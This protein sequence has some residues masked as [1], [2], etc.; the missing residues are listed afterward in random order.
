MRPK[1]VDLGFGDILSA[2]NE[3]HKYSLGGSVAV[4][5]VQV[6]VALDVDL[7][8][9]VEKNELPLLAFPPLNLRDIV[10]SFAAKDLAL[11][12]LVASG[13]FGQKF[14]SL[15]MPQR[16]SAACLAAALV[17]LADP[18]NGEGKW[19]IGLEILRLFLTVTPMS[20]ALRLQRTPDPTEAQIETSLNSLLESILTVYD[21]TVLGKVIRGA[22]ASAGV[23]AANVM[24]AEF[25][26][27]PGPCAARD[28]EMKPLPGFAHLMLALGVCLLLAAFALLVFSCF[29]HCQGK[30]HPRR[31]LI[32]PSNLEDR[33]QVARTRSSM[34]HVRTS[35]RSIDGKSVSV[36]VESVVDGGSSSTTSCVELRRQTSVDKLGS[37]E[38][39]DRERLSLAE[40][41][42]IPAAV[43]HGIG[44]L[45]FACFACFLASNTLVGVDM[46]LALSSSSTGG[47]A[48]SE[49]TTATGRVEVPAIFSFT[50]GNSVSDMWNAKCYAFAVAILLF[51]GVWPYLKLFVVLISWY[52]RPLPPL[53]RGVISWLRFT[54]V[55]RERMLEFLDAS[56]KLGLVDS[57]VLVVFAAS[58]RFVWRVDA[59]EMGIQ[60]KYGLSFFV[61][62]F[63][64][65]VSLIL[66]H[67]VLF[68]HRHVLSQH[69]RKGG[70]G[71]A[72]L[73]RLVR[74]SEMKDRSI[75][76]GLFVLLYVQ[77][78]C[79]SWPIVTFEFGGAA[80]VMNALGNL[81]NRV[82]CSLRDLVS[83]LS[84][85]PARVNFDWNKQVVQGEEEIMGSPS[86]L[87][88]RRLSMSSRSSWVGPQ[89]ST[90]T[91]R[92][93]QTSSFA[94]SSTSP[95]FPP[96]GTSA[97]LISLIQMAVFLFGVL[98]HGVFLVV[99]LLLWTKP[100]SARL[101]YLIFVTAQTLRAWAA[102]DV[103]ALSV[104]LASSQCSSFVQFILQYGTLSTLCNA[105][106]ENSG[107]PCFTVDAAVHWRTVFWLIVA[108]VGTQVV[109]VVIFRD[110]SQVLSEERRTSVL[111]ML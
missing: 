74:A 39:F 107:V 81:P 103:F 7:V 26:K 38:D 43:S 80:G 51:S 27:N 54:T 52:K 72:P 89:S 60:I 91:P 36:E 59:T 65:I 95:P 29:R 49:T 63:A 100:V 53:P 41:P 85:A 58:F 99:L 64:T 20:V 34:M 75:V 19:S 62:V 12:A 1:R 16:Q 4:S 83:G 42:E 111:E 90:F 61:F 25:L 47:L 30:Y 21:R 77:V 105:V 98:I 109:A 50:L 6:A 76:I 70:L 22:T 32:P 82:T 17:D 68:V 14:A 93:E 33:M 66:G 40:C 69:I 28:M 35:R 67:V 86:W 10:V 97:L 18:V 73:R 88:E 94:G 84:A 44:C 106:E 92:S 48:L 110:V 108:A 31:S 37:D 11:D 102:T 13:L 55:R 78:M 96:G 71:R 45:V 2:N 15:D 46:N 8:P 104:V 101:H 3:V 57:F 24:I 9:I 79:V 87:G 56:G 5:D 23:G